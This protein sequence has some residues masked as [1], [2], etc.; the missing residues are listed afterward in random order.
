M[1]EQNKHLQERLLQEWQCRREI[2]TYYS[3]ALLLLA[4]ED[5]NAY[6]RWQEL[7]GKLSLA[8]IDLIHAHDQLQ[9]YEQ[10]FARENHHLPFA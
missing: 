2:V 6:Q 1:R 4:S 9:S 3:R 8:Q 7:S 10:E 5:R